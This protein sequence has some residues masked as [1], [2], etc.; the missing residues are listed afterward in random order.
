MS[1]IFNMADTWNSGGIPY[2]AIKMNVT[3]TASAA[4]SLLMDLQVGGVTKFRVT[5]AGGLIAANGSASNLTLMCVSEVTANQAG[6]ALYTGQAVFCHGGG[7]IFKFTLGNPG[8][9]ALGYNS[10]ISMGTGA[11]R[12]FN[13][14]GTDISSGPLNIAPGQSTGSATPG[15]INLKGTAAGATSATPQTLVDVLTITN[16]LLA[17]WGDGANQAYGTATGTKLGTSVSQKIGFWNAAPVIQQA[18]A[19]QAAV[20]DT[21]GA[22]YTAT[23]QTMLANLKTLVNRLR[24]D[25]VTVGLIKGSA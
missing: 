2:T 7:E 17:T 19:A 22:A 12:A 10:T 18:N 24:T 14:A 1:D 16:S 23:E 8:D 4:A 9:F 20:T 21:A 3:D 15:V 5:K 11:L 25:M 13:A 6:L